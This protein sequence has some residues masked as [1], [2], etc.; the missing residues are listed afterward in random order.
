MKGKILDYTVQI[1]E[2]IISGDDGNRYKFSGTEWKAVT[3]PMAGACVDFEVSDQT[4][5]G[6][7]LVSGAAK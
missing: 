5:H 2:G 1:N 6:V 7:Y 3:P 4:A